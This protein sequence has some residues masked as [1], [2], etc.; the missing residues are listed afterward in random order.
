MSGEGRRT[1][2]GTGARTLQAGGRRTTCGDDGIDAGT[3][4]AAGV[5]SGW[6]SILDRALRRAD[7]RDLRLG[8]AVITPVTALVVLVNVLTT[9]ADNSVV[10]R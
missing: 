3:S 9:L 8:L 7:P 6:R 5:T 10:A 2:A 1:L 4:G